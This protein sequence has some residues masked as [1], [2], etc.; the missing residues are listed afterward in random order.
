[1][2]TLVTPKCV[3]CGQNGFVKVTEEQQEFAKQKLASGSYYADAYPFLS[4][5]IVE[6]FISGTHPECWNQMFPPEEGE[7]D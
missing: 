5:S 7:E 3:H 1:M 6:M 2:I 4:P